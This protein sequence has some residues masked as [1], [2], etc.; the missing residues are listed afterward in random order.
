MDFKLS[1][2]IE[3]YRQRIRAFVADYILPLEA[4]GTNFDA[5]EMIDLEPLERLRTMAKK[6]GL[7]AF[8]MPKSRGGQ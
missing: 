2:E 3:D 5:H 6:A 4:N 8:Q 1:P 7:W